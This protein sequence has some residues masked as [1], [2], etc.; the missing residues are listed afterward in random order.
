MSP[1]VLRSIQGLPPSPP[2]T[3]EGTDLD[4]NI[5]QRNSFS[6]PDPVYLQDKHK[7]GAKR[8]VKKVLKSSEYLKFLM[9]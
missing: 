8:R 1:R 7:S 2:P 3:S 4:K 5:L 9:E 6:N